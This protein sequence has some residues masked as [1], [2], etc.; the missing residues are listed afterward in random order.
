MCGASVCVCVCVT[1]FL[2]ACQSVFGTSS[3]LNFDEP[4]RLSTRVSA[5]P[6]VVELKGY[7]SLFNTTLEMRPD[8]QEEKPGEHLVQK[9]PSRVE[10]VLF[11]H[12]LFPS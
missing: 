2:S 5:S 1:V 8:T 7:Y 6:R 10:F 11:I 9:K 4:V 3:P 12:S